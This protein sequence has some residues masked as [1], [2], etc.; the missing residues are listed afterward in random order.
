MRYLTL[1][2]VLELH[3]QVIQ[4]SGGAMGVLNL[5]ALESALAQPRM[6]FAGEDLYP[7]LVEKAAV[8]GYALIQNHP[9]ADGNNADGPCSDGSLSR[10]ERL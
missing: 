4:Q 2:E 9:F 6:A 1:P 3:S 7:T 8:L 5:P 10:V